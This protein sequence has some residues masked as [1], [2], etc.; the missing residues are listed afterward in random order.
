MA[1]LLPGLNDASDDSDIDEELPWQHGWFAPS[2]DE[3]N[4]DE[5]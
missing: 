2:S 1:T 4:E 5:E 3:E